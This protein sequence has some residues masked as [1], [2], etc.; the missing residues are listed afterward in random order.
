MKAIK[1][2]VTDLLLNSTEDID[3][4]YQRTLEKYRGKFSDSEINKA[5]EDAL[6]DLP[7]LN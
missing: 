6:D 5:F 1:K 3:Q 2:Y 7:E 4:L